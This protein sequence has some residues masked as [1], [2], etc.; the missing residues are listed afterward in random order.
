MPLGGDI[1]GGASNA[2]WGFLVVLV[3]L[4][5]VNMA[6]TWRTYDKPSAD[7]AAE[8]RKANLGFSI[9]PIILLGVGL[10]GRKYLEQ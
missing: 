4:L 1:F 5:I 10:L 6:L 2:E 7:D 3:L 9:A 8:V